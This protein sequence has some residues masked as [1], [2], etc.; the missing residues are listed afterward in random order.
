MSDSHLD[1]KWLKRPERAAER[2]NTF[3]IGHIVELT[4]ELGSTGQEISDA[5]DAAE[6]ASRIRHRA[7]GD[8]AWLAIVTR[9][10]L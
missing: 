9:E 8:A 1:G 7:A 3:R 6:Q 5:I 10:R 2:P 4:D